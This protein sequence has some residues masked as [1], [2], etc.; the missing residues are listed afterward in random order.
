MLL[1]VPEAAS[2]LKATERQVYRWI[3]EGEIPSQH[4]RGQARFNRS[5]LLEWATGRR[6]PISLEAFDAGLDP[7][8]RA[9]SLARA[10]RVGGVHH[11]SL[12]RASARFDGDLPG[13]D[14]DAALRA[15]VERTP[16]PGVD[17]E[18]LLDVL[19]AR[20]D[21]DA[22]ADGIALPQVRQP[23]IAPGAPAALS[24]CHFA[25]PFGFHRDVEQ[26]EEKL[27]RSVLTIV[28]P[29]VR[30]HLQMVAHLAHA[31]LDDGFRS[32]LVRHAPVDELAAEAAR[33]E[34]AP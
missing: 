1:T 2:L 17:P 21:L 26:T 27:V 18:F 11:I 7:E 31:L 15:V 4:V 3:D 16:M 23:I 10:L 5:E 9:P 6:L 19:R 32:A 13:H 22:D 28:S 25:Q 29:T 20:K 8:D 12:A 14:R 33:L 34:A 24:V 30:S